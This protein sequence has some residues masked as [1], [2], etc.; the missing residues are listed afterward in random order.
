ME[1]RKGGEQCGDAG[2]GGRKLGVGGSDGAENR[3][4]LHICP[5]LGPF[6]AAVSIW[7]SERSGG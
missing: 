4:T 6:L 2:K 7:H 5:F 1:K 3:L